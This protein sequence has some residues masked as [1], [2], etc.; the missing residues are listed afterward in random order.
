MFMSLFMSLVIVCIV[1]GIIIAL[2]ILKAYMLE[3]DILLNA[4]LINPGTL[5]G[6]LNS[7]QIIFF[8]AGKIPHL[9]MNITPFFFLNIFLFFVSLSV[10]MQMND[11]MSEIENH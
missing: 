7:I 10:Y 1:V 3:K 11:W 5:I 2:F 8:N 9:S 6:I 4:P